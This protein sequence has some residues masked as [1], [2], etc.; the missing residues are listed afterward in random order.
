[1][2]VDNKVNGAGARRESMSGIVR[3][4]QSQQEVVAQDQARLDRALQRSIIRRTSIAG[5]IGLVYGLCAGIILAAYDD[6]GSL[7]LLEPSRLTVAD[8]TQV[9]PLPKESMLEDAAVAHE[10]ATQLAPAARSPTPVPSPCQSATSSRQ[11][12]PGPLPSV[13]AELT[14][15]QRSRDVTARET[16]PVLTRPV[17]DCWRRN[18]RGRQHRSQRIQE[19]QSPCQN[20]HSSRSTPSRRWWPKRRSRPRSVR[21]KHRAM[22]SLAAGRQGRR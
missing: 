19:R 9:K 14:C 2:I 5:L 17:L 10:L 11:W 8:P 6:F 21:L 16:R 22:P 7:S 1:M 4:S 3:P 15:P 12:R 13:W 20:R 18:A